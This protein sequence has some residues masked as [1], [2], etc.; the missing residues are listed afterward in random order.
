MENLAIYRDCREIPDGI[1]EYYY[2]TVE[3]QVRVVSW[4]EQGRGTLI[5]S[6]SSSDSDIIDSM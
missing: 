4:H 2:I 1:G 6:S 3:F 5:M